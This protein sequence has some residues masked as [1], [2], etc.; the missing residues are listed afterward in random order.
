MKIPDHEHLKPA[1]KCEP[2]VYQK[3]D[4][5]LT[6]DLMT[7]VA[8]AGTNHEENQPPHLKVKDANQAKRIHLTIYKQNMVDYRTEITYG[9]YAGPE[10]RYCPA[11]VYE[12]VDD[13][14]NDKRLH[15]HSA[16]FHKVCY[17]LDLQYKSM[18]K[19]VYIA[20][21]ATSRILPRI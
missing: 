18:P 6:F 17:C 15:I 4:G 20:K 10:S 11:G 7:N 12:W 9:V 1:A 8:R 14:N 16:L 19:I 13:G 2:I 21:L 3:P 5:K